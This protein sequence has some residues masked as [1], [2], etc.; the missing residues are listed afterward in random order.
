MGAL[1]MRAIEH[2]GLSEVAARALGGVALTDADL[3]KARGADLLALAALVDAVRAKH[4]GDV[5]RLCHGKPDGAVLAEP[6]LGDAEGP[7]ATDALRELALLRLATPP[8]RAV[9]VHYG[10]L[11]RELALVALAFGADALAFVPLADA[12]KRDELE[13]MVAL[14]GRTARWDGASGA[15]E[16]AR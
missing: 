15:Q 8:A 7:T 1:A 10:R 14:A 6:A 16:L 4:R 13:R 9:A 5:V 12:Q 3:A 11:G 2:A